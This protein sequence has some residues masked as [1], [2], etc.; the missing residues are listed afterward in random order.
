MLEVCNQTGTFNVIIMDSL[1]MASDTGTVTTLRALCKSC[2]KFSS[3]HRWRVTAS[4]AD[5]SVSWLDKAWTACQIKRVSDFVYL[6][7]TV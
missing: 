5:H 2:E 7:M 3:Q 1:L 6:E 4:E